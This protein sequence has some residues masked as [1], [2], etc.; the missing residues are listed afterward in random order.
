MFPQVVTAVG[1]TV[2]GATVTGQ[3][4][5]HDKTIAQ[6]GGDTLERGRVVQPTM[7]GE[8]RRVTFIAPGSQGEVI[9]VDVQRLLTPDMAQTHG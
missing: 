6:Q 2:L 5:G 9:T 7:Q 4:R 8:H 1:P 3:I